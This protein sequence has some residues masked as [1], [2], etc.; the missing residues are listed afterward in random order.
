MNCVSC[1]AVITS[2]Q[3]KCPYCGSKNPEY[4]R[5][6][7]ILRSLDKQQEAAE[8]EVKRTFK[9]IWQD[10]LC[11]ICLVSSILL[12]VGMFA[13]V[14]VSS[15]VSGGVILFRGLG[16]GEE[17]QAK[18]EEYYQ[19]GDYGKLDQYMND[20]E[21]FDP[22]KNYRYGQAALL[23]DFMTHFRVSVYPYIEYMDGGNVD[24]RYRPGAW[25]I[26]YNAQMVLCIKNS[27]YPTVDPD[28]QAQYDAYRKEIK[29][30]FVNYLN[31][32]EEEFETWFANDSVTL[33]EYVEIL[34]E[35]NDIIDE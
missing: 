18:M 19:A 34:D 7:L 28:N 4:E 31:I 35:R 27:V 3:K 32:T 1:G 2:K 16:K 10:K 25:S 12:F 21:L 15:F 26:L 17:Q 23:Y 30:V 24:L 20:Y 29:N 13:A 9:T 6:F 8:Q 5:K 11:N 14:I 22:E 33:S